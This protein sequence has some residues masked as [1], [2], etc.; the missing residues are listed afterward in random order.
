MSYI[1][2]IIVNLVLSLFISSP[3]IRGW[4]ELC[5]H[6]SSMV[7][8]G[9]ILN[10]F[11]LKPLNH[12]KR[13]LIRMFLELHF[14]K[15]LSF[16]EIRNPEWLTQQDIDVGKW[17]YKTLIEPKLYKSNHWMVLCKISIFGWIEDLRSILHGCHYR[18]NLTWDAYGKIFLNYFYLKPLHYFDSKLSWNVLWMVHYQMSI[19]LYG[20]EIRNSRHHLTNFQQWTL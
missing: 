14:R 10:H 16:V 9:N 13:S 7:L 11:S 4:C 17:K 15:Y 5:D 20:F 12:S 2:F 1:H 6:F 3:G 8:T 19:F 18:T